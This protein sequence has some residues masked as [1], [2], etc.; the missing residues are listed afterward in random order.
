[1]GTGVNSRIILKPE[2]EKSI[3]RRHPWIF[4]GAIDGTVGDPGMGDTVEVVSSRGEFL[5]WA[6]FS[7]VSRIRARVWSFDGSERIDEC[8]FH[9]RISGSISRRK[10]MLHREVDTNAYRLVYSESDGLPGLIADRY[11][12][13]IVLQSLTAGSEKH[14]AVFCQ[15]LSEI[16]GCRTIY[17]RSDSDLRELEGLAP[18]CG[19]I[20]GKSEPLKIEI[21]EH[22][23]KYFVDAVNG[24]KTGFYLD[25]RENRKL[26]RE[27]T[28]GKK[29][30][31]CFCYTGGFT[32][33]ASAG[34]AESVTS[35]DSSENA[36]RQGRQN[37]ELN[38]FDSGRLEWICGDVFHVLRRYVEDGAEFDIV[39][40]D[41]PKFADSRSKLP[42]A[43]RAYKDI[44]MFALRLLRSGGFLF[45]FSCSGAMGKE[46]FQRIAAWAAMDAGV[47]ARIVRQLSQAPDHPIALNFPES[48]YVKGLIIQIG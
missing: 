41:P 38:G 21:M 42:K 34:G 44:N 14:K 12:D 39:V 4:S 29:V 27:Y 25:Q 8:F 9:K 16:T 26:L 2:R 46:D 43:E 47:D 28:S 23:I 5:A 19:L 18:T 32:M 3:H 7:P 6:A 37:A 13:V 35:V 45:T 31:N 30:L 20:S 24:Q 33:N 48:E 22:G 10:S 17:E 15:I 40:L 11:D 36:L 1:M